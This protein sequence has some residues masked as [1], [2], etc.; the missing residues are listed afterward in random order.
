[1]E[2]QLSGRRTVLRTVVVG[3]LLLSCIATPG[4]ESRSKK[5]VAV[6]N[7][8]N[9]SVAS[10]APSGLFGPGGDNVGKGVSIQLIQKLLPSGKYTIVDQMAVEKL[11]KEQKEED[12]ERLDAYGRA[13]RIG[14]LLGLDAMIIGAVT[15]FG[16]EA[17]TGAKEKQ[18]HGSM[19]GA[20]VHSRKSKAFVEISAQIFN[21]TTGEVMA[22]FTGA[23][24]STNFGEITTIST[25]GKS[26][27]S[28]EMLGSEFVDNLLGEA[29]GKAVD[30]IATQL[31]LFADKIP[32]LV[33]AVQ[34]LVAE[35]AGNTV[36]L[37]IGKKSGVKIGDQLEV[38]RDPP[39]TTGTAAPVMQ[40]VAERIG[41][42]TVTE[43]A[44]D[45]ATTTFSGKSEPRVGDR[46]T[47]TASPNTAHQFRR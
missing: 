36:T 23:G 30:L 19:L 6:L 14:R 25:K 37:N 28:V 29:T 46:V 17:K 20:G 1:V 3:W 39:T 35:V 8:D 21:N 43:V 4:Q 2:F 24:E 18:V 47:G 45:Y 42:V 27:T 38:L 44:D 41:Q 11:L 31:N 5:R 7:F 33:L 9:P 10:D 40:P 26:K 32:L 16:P 34:G 13:A 15:R 22:T 12:G